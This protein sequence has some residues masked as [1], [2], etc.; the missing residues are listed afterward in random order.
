MFGQNKIVKQEKSE[1]CDGTIPI[2]E[3]FKTLQGEGHFSG[4]PSIFVRVRD[5]I[6]RCHFCDTEFSKGHRFTIDEILK[7]INKLRNDNINLVVI[8]GG[9][10][11]IHQSTKRLIF[12]LLSEGF[13]VQVETCGVVTLEDLPHNNPNFSIV[14][15]PKTG[16]INQYI[17]DH[18]TSFKY[19]IT[20][21]EVDEKDGLPNKSTQI[22]EQTLK[23]CRPR[24][25]AKVYLTPCDPHTTTEDYIDNTNQAIESCL[26]YGYTLNL[27]MHK[28][29]GLP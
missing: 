12:K 5:C 21:G 18:A 16:K 1:D 3:I 25:G 19:I 29:V 10:P 22:K 8:T 20:D 27:Q 6:L 14:V 4:V 11:F 7:E 24:P 26:K 23:L 2:V 13:I 28:I 9:E 15:S 17:Y